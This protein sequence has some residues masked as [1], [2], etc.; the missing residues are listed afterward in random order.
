MESNLEQKMYFLLKLKHFG[1]IELN[2]PK[3]QEIDD[4]VLKFENEGG[5]NLYAIYGEK[6]ELNFNED[7]IM[8]II[9][10]PEKKERIEY[11]IKLIKITILV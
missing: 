9:G 5:D 8:D 2:D 6:E 1:K 11:I 10:N 3:N 7:E 4:G